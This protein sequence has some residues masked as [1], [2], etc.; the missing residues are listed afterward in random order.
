ML[1]WIQNKFG[2]GRAAVENAPKPMPSEVVPVA[3]SGDGSPWK[4]G[5]Y[6]S[7]MKPIRMLNGSA[8]F[9]KTCGDWIED[10]AYYSQHLRTHRPLRGSWN[11]ESPRNKRQSPD[12]IQP[13]HEQ[14]VQ[15]M[16]E[17]GAQMVRSGTIWSSGDG[18]GIGP[19]DREF[20]SVEEAASVL[21][22]YGAS[23]AWRER[24][25]KF[26]DEPWCGGWELSFSRSRVSP[27]L[28]PDNERTPAA[29]VV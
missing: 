29:V 26:G 12:D 19:G 20:H 25:H 11:Y 2:I 8:T 6:G 10:G 3:P 22:P 13:D 1:N 23:V 28:L 18:P 24:H 9:C 15:S 5:K 17:W 16:R 27:E 7:D 21:G 14:W 4:R